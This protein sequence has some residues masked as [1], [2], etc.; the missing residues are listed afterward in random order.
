M[1]TRIY[2]CG[3][4]G[5]AS[6][7]HARSMWAASADVERVCVWLACVRACASACEVLFSAA[8]LGGATTQVYA[9]TRTR[10]G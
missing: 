3:P 5:G 1:A 4:L 2:V 9:M 10:E 8:Q 6:E 7:C